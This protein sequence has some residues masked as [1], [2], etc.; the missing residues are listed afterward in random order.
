MS[1]PSLAGAG[2]NA[3]TTLPPEVRDVVQGMCQGMLRRI[4]LWLKR[5]VLE[6]P[7]LAQAVPAL[8][9]SVRLYQNE[10][11]EACL[12]QVMAVGRSL[13]AARAAHP[14]LPPL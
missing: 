4:H 8:R 14:A 10:R 13:E 3:G 5:A 6:V 11:Y 7:E 9:E 2:P 1:S 12:S